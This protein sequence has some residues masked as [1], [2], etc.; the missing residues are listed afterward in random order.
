MKPLS[1]AQHWMGCPEEEHKI[2]FQNRFQSAEVID[3]IIDVDEEI[4]EDDIENVEKY[5]DYAEIT[6][7]K[8]STITIMR[9][10]IILISIILL[11]SR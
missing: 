3:S 9:Y 2:I 1:S 5:A 8:S 10:P 11:S 6:T 7:A 4:F